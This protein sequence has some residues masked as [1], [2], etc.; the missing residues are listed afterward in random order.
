[1]LSV[2]GERKYQV[3]VS[4]TY[5]DLLEARQE[6]MQGLLALGMIPTGMELYPTEQN[7]QWPLIQKVIS[8]CDYY[9]VMVGGRYGTLSPMGLSYTHREFIY[10]ATKK[11]PVIALLHDHPELLP[12]EGR[13]KTREGEVRLADF[14]QLLQQKCMFR[15]WNTPGDLAQ[16]I[17]KAMP[18]MIKEH[19]A[20]G[21]VRA[22]QVT[23]LEAQ[24]E[25]Q[26]LRK[27]IGELEQEV[28]EHNSGY[29]PPIDS[30]ARGSDRVGLQ[31]SCNVYVKGDCKVVM[32]ES[33][34]TWDAVFACVAPQ[35]MHEVAEPVMR[36]AIEE[37][38]SE[39]ALKDVQG[40]I[41]KAHAVRNV[42]LST[43]SFNQVKIQLRALGLIRKSPRREGQ[44]GIHW[45]LTPL[46]DR[47]MTEVLAQ[48]RR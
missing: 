35:M 43:G 22:G 45:Q 30:L 3:F 31:Y 16:V 7:N 15:F 4:S 9:V 23:D 21:W 14:R 19:P 5:T 12:A 20:P 33:A 11:K 37:Y 26:E 1:M 2:S 47:T 18:A 8:E 42:V 38:L 24:R 36:Q 48:Q 17:K 40:Q 10:A 46:G 41:P 6:L 39:G 13:E 27:R 34:M 44:A 25:V 29:R 32:A 28:E